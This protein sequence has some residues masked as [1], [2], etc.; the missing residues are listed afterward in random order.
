M[1]LGRGSQGGRDIDDA[2][3]LERKGERDVERYAGEDWASFEILY[4]R[5]L[6][7][8]MMNE[9]VRAIHYTIKMISDKLERLPAWTSIIRRIQNYVGPQSN[10]ESKER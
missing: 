6:T 2:G 3:F 4:G 9:L 5:L 7:L 1:E 10:S 8:L